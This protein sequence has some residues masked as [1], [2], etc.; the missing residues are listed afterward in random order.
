ML[1]LRCIN[2]DLKA[3][4]LLDGPW[5]LENV[6]PVEVESTCAIV[7][8][9]GG[10]LLATG[11]GSTGSERYTATFVHCDGSGVGS[12]SFSSGRS[13]ALR[14]GDRIARQQ[15]TLLSAIRRRS[16]GLDLQQ[17]AENAVLLAAT[18]WKIEV[19]LEAPSK[20]NLCTP[21]EVEHTVTVTVTELPEIPAP[22]DAG[23]GWLTS[24]GATITAWCSSCVGV[25]LVVDQS[26]ES[27]AAAAAEK[28]SL[29][30]QLG[31]LTDGWTESAAP[32]Q[33]N[34]SAM[35]TALGAH[36]V[37]AGN[38]SECSRAETIGGAALDSA[39]TCT[40]SIS[41][42][43][44]LAAGY[45]IGTA[46]TLA[47]CELGAG[48]EDFTAAS[49]PTVPCAT[50]LFVVS[51]KV[52]HRSF[53]ICS[54]DA[55]RISRVLDISDAR[56]WHPSTL[57]G[58]Q[59]DA[60]TLAVGRLM[61]H[62]A[63]EAGIV[64]QL[65]DTDILM[66]GSTGTLEQK[67]SALELASV[68]EDG[69]VAGSKPVFGCATIDSA[70]GIVIATIGKIAFCWGCSEPLLSISM[71]N[72]VAF[73]AADNISAVAISKEPKGCNSRIAY[74]EWCSN[75]IISGKLRHDCQAITFENFSSDSAY[76]HAPALIRSL[77]FYGPTAL[78]AGLA[79]GIV[80]I[81]EHTTGGLSQRQAI[82][83]GRTPVSLCLFAGRNGSRNGSNPEDGA[84]NF[85]FCASSHGLVVS[86]STDLT[87]SRVRA[88]SPIIGA[89]ALPG[90][91]V[92]TMN[93]AWITS[94]EHDPCGQGE[95]R[96][97]AGRIDPDAKPRWRRRRIGSTPLL[98]C[99][100]PATGLLIVATEET[101][102]EGEAQTI[103]SDTPSEQYHTLRVYDPNTLS[104]RGQMKLEPNHF[105]TAM[106][107]LRVW[108]G[109]ASPNRGNVLQQDP[110]LPSDCFAVATVLQQQPQLQR[111][112][113]SKTAGIIGGR[114]ALSIL[115]LRQRWAGEVVARQAVVLESLKGGSCVVGDG[116]DGAVSCV[117]PCRDRDG[118]MA[119][120]VAHGSVFSIFGV[121]AAHVSAADAGTTV[122]N[123]SDGCRSSSGIEL[124]V[125]LDL[126]AERHTVAG[127]ATAL[128]FCEGY[129][130]CSELQPGLSLF[131]WHDDH[132]RPAALILVARS[133]DPSA[134]GTTAA[135]SPS[136]LY[137]LESLLLSNR[138]S[139]SN[140]GNGCSVAGVASRRQRRGLVLWVI[141]CGAR[142]G[143]T[144]LE[145]AAERELEVSE[146]PADS[147]DNGDGV[148]MEGR[149]V[150][151]LPMLIDNPVDLDH[152]LHHKTSSLV[153]NLH[154]G[155][156]G[157]A[158]KDV[159]ATAVVVE[160]DGTISALV[161]SA[162]VEM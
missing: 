105:V 64:C 127:S 113:H 77:Q 60:P 131:R 99:E 34:C 88:P 135:S 71:N 126:L 93:M 118:N 139:D 84:E 22:S 102:V 116:L 17:P 153:A 45:G 70:A 69:I 162:P 66:M 76:V 33:L 57:P 14:S 53:L 103:S 125:R 114:A 132:S 23:Y 1:N 94:E 149:R 147:A 16:T 38:Q 50:R 154:S 107:N 123:G 82:R 39:S 59:T 2:I 51:C 95:Q 120:A 119:I 109:H 29:R 124:Q 65:T 87:F 11:C 68:A 78:I 41:I 35:F 91:T 19:S 121:T 148:T 13:S 161:Q 63:T 10:V 110:K 151:G 32:T 75:R 100:H 47:V 159:S 145:H 61:G 160:A 15:N 115:R 18:P 101:V 62:G 52:S 111:E 136:F 6:A 117:E 122:G 92:S 108:Y 49:G 134:K 85:V 156:I 30:S 155:C 56:A 4:K 128:S 97:V 3:A 152:V 43:R 72:W 25:S 46:G 36:F 133:M 55:M 146:I 21:G 112:Q 48:L 8:L 143:V 79:S 158:S 90:S 96:L 67:V 80:L 83:I 74:G 40:A 104:M 86:G 7:S 31:E 28:V 137:G 141:A 130:L 9:P 157:R 54:C 44:S 138:H 142:G 81:C 58:L 27:L 5:G 20:A 106:H 24:A 73:I 26:S 129:F 150:P 144:V 89:V 140:V 98:L 42:D 37:S 12:T